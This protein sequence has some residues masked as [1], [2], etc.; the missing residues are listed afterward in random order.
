MDEFIWFLN[1]DK[2]GLKELGYALYFQPA[3]LFLEIRGKLLTQ[4]FELLLSSSP[5]SE[6]MNCDVFFCFHI[7]QFA[8]DKKNTTLTEARENVIAKALE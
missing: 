3:W 5:S 7:L 6:Q 2:C 8:Q 4:V 1:T